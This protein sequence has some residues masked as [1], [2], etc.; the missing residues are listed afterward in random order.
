MSETIGGSTIPWTGDN[1][2]IR[3]WWPNTTPSI[4]YVYVYPNYDYHWHYHAPEPKTPKYCEECGTLLEIDD[5][6]TTLKY[7]KYTGVPYRTGYFLYRCPK[8]TARK[9]KE[10]TNDRVYAESYEYNPI[11]V[12]Y[13][14]DTSEG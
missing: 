2:A 11:T 10:H 4:P 12:T 9:N 14:S 13:T 3:D 6:N 1:W 7:D 5:T 8:W